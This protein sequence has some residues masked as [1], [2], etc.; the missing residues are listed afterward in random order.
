MLKLV[1]VNSTSRRCAI[2]RMSR[3]Q[4]TMIVARSANALAL[5]VVMGSDIVLVGVVVGD[6]QEGWV[7]GTGASPIHTIWC[8]IVPCLFHTARCIV[9]WRGYSQRRNR[10]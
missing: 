6:M 8:R 9:F 10:M 1:S 7:G 2:G 4:G 5:G 3:W